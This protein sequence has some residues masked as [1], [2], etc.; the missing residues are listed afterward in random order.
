MREGNGS[1]VTQPAATQSTATPA[2]QSLRVNHQPRQNR[3]A[4]VPTHQMAGL[5]IASTSDDHVW[6]LHP[7]DGHTWVPCA[8]AKLS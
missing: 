1:Q 7:E 3:I 4:T 5:P 8:F 2:R 6:P